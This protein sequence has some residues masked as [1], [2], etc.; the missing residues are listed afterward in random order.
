MHLRR[1]DSSTEGGRG[2]GIGPGCVSFEGGFFFALPLTAAELE[3]CADG[4]S[5]ALPFIAA[6]LEGWSEG[7]VIAL[8][9]R[10]AELEV[11][12]VL[13]ALAFTIEKIEE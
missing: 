10:A 12:S 5:I 7:L 8:P 2:G 11:G 4:F 3:R 13:N 6:E 1:Y 9:F